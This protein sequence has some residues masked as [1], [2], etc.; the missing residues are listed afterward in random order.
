MSLTWMDDWPVGLKLNTPLSG[1]LC[2]TF[3]GMADIWD[4]ESWSLSRC[5]K[6]ALG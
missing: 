6:K 2:T 3:G 5:L 1:L 4:C